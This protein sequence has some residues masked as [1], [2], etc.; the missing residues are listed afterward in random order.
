MPTTKDRFLHPLVNSLPKDNYNCLVYK[1]TQFR[2]L[3]E[4]GEKF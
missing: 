2:A 3:L 1:I 4:K